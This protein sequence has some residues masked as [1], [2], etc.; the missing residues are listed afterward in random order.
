MKKLGKIK[1]LTI[2]SLSAV[3]LAAPIAFAQTTGTTQDPQKVTR[4]EGHGKGM[5]RVGVNAARAWRGNARH[6]V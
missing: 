3:A 1:T 4:G 2:A 6:D 5:T